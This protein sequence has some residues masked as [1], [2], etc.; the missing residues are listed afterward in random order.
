MDEEA[1]QGFLESRKA[2][3]AGRRPPERGKP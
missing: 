2:V 3:I 1:R